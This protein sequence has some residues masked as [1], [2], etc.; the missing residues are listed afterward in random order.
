MRVVFVSFYLFQAF[1]LASPLILSFGKKSL[2]YNERI[3]V[4]ISI[5]DLTRPIYYSC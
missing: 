2:K 5:W 1:W 3:P 4:E